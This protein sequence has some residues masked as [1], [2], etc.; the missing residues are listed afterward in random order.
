MWGK[1]NDF[2]PSPE[3]GW[4]KIQGGVQTAMGRESQ[5]VHCAS[6]QSKKER[7]AKAQTTARLHRS[8]K[9]SAV[10]ESRTATSPGAGGA[11]VKIQKIIGGSFLVL[12]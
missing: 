3:A 9:S 7:G 10:Q 2:L 5:A 6:A 12:K 8:R 1:K 11:G 4:E